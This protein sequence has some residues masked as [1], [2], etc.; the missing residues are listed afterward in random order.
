MSPEATEEQ[1]F[2]PISPETL[3]NANTEY[4]VA[5]I[6][7]QSEAYKQQLA[8]AGDVMPP[9]MRIKKITG[10]GVVHI[11]FTNA[12][13]FPDNLKDMINDQTTKQEN[14]LRNL[15]EEEILFNL[16]MVS[17]SEEEAVD[18]MIG[19]EVT[20][21]TS[22][23]MDVQMNFKKPIEVSQGDEADFIIVQGQ[24]SDYR[25]VNGGSLPP[26]LIKKMELPRM[27]ASQA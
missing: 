16:L 3:V 7:R 4:V 13:E 2:Q 8:S 20:S 12:M 22:T 25:D 14:Q 1:L 10:E 19:W 18:N 11:I 17:E 21:V 23:S 15:A 27:F 5:L 9:E 26:S 6:E 24:L